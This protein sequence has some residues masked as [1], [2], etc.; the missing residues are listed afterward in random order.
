M[1]TELRKL[2]E[3]DVQQ[4]LRLAFGGTLSVLI[5]KMLN[6]EFGAFYCIYPVL[7][8]GLVPRLNATLVRQFFAQSA[9]ISVEVAVLYGFFGHRPSVI[10]P[11][12]FAL[13]WWRFHLMAQG[14]LFFFGALGAVFLSIQLNFA[15]YPETNIFHMVANNSAATVMAALIAGLMFFLFPDKAP[16]SP[17][18]KPEKDACSI[19]HESLLGAT[20]A[21]LSF[22]CFQSFDLHDSLSAQVATVLLLFPMHWNGSRFAGKK[23]AYGTVLGCTLGMM[24]M[25]LLY[26]HHDLLPLIGL[27]LFPVMM[28]CARWHMLENGVSGVGFAALTTQSILYGQ[29]L[30]PNHDIVFDILYR[31]TSVSA[32]VLFTL[33]AIFVM[34]KLLNLSRWTKHA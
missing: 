21:T 34:H 27:M 4:T 8:L 18:P 13:F 14:K 23:R 10:V 7:I 24:V 12:I 16:R 15:S 26:D 9:I 28:L 6:L 32:A 5:C 19:R 25:V 2:S 1:S 17:K 22:I 20:V 33:F 11:I 31:F 30:Q 29:Y 3:N